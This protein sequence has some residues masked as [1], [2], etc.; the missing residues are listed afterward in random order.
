MAKTPGKQQASISE[1]GGLP[2]E[3]EADTQQ[4]QIVAPDNSEIQPEPKVQNVPPTANE[5]AETPDMQEKTAANEVAGDHSADD[6]DE[7]EVVVVKGQTLRH[8]R[9]TYTENS[10]LFLPHSDASRLIDLG[11]VPDVK[12]LRQQEVRISGPSITVDDGVKIDRGN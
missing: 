11:V 9:E 4:E 2:P 6:S 12:A 8:S 7:M 3:F 5:P 1:L 10:R